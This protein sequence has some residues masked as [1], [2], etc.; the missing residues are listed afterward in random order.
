MYP[1]LAASARLQSNIIH[2]LILQDMSARYARTRLGVFTSVLEPV[3]VVAAMY[4]IRFYI[5]GQHAVGGIPM[6]LFIVTGFMTDFSFRIVAGQVIN[7]TERRASSRMFPQ[8]TSLDVIAARSVSG[9]IV[10][11]GAMIITFAVASVITGGLPS[12]LLI[13]LIAGAFTYALAISSGVLM[14]VVLRRYPGLRVLIGSLLRINF[15]LSGAAFLGTELPRSMLVYVSWNPTFHVVEL[16]RE[17]WFRHYVSP[18]AN[19][20]YIIACILGMLAIALPLERLTNKKQ[21]T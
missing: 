4:V 15:V 5:Q 8:V 20:F 9:S 2:A 16:M 1:S 11:A 10:S 13:C 3:V 6:V 14:G 21:I 17:G 19:P 7:A 18:V 12:N